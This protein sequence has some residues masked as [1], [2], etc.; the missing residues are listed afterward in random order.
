MSWAGRWAVEGPRT[1]RAR[2]VAG[3]LGR[4]LFEDGAHL[5]RAGATAGAGA[6]DGA[7]AIDRW[8]GGWGLWLRLGLGLGLR[9]QLRLRPGQ[10]LRPSGTARTGGASFVT[11]STRTVATPCPRSMRSMRRLRSGRDSRLI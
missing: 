11:A 3:T 7:G 6:T 2:Y 10:V 5:V 9:L 8:G 4:K 1:E